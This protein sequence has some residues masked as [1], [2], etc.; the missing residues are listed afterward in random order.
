MQSVE[1]DIASMLRAQA[2]ITRATQAVDAAFITLPTDWVK[3]EQV[4]YACCGGTLAMADYWTGPIA[5]GP[6]C[7]CGCAWGDA[8]C[9]YRIVGDCIEFLPHPRVDIN[10]PPVALNVVYYAKPKPLKVAA[11]TNA[12][13]ERH[14]QIYL[15]GVVRY[16]AHVG[17]GRRSR[18]TDDHA[19]QR[20]RRR[21]QQ[22][23]RGCPVF[24]RT[25]ARRAA[26]VLRHERQQPAMDARLHPLG[27]RVEYV[28]GQ[29]G[30]R[31]R[32][33]IPAAARWHL[34]T[35]RC[36]TRRPDR[37]ASGH[38]L[39]QRRCAVHRLIAAMA[40]LVAWPALAQTPT[41]DAVKLR[42]SGQIGTSTSGNL[43]VGSSYPFG[44]GKSGNQRNT[45]VGVGTMPVINNA[46]INV[47]VGYNAM[48]V[49]ISSS[50]EV[51]IGMQALSR[52]VSGAFNTAVG[53]NAGLGIT[54]GNANT[55]LGH[56]AMGGDDFNPAPLTSGQSVALGAW[57]MQEA[58][59]GG[60]SACVGTNSCQS[61]TTG[62]GN[63]AVGN[64]AL[65]GGPGAAAVNT[66]NDASNNVAIGSLALRSSQVNDQTA[67]GWQ[68]LRDNTTGI[69]HVA[70]GTLNLA[71]SVN[72]IRNTAIGFEVMNA[73]NGGS[74][75]TGVG[76]EGI[77]PAGDRQRQHGCRV[78]CLPQADHR[79]VEYLPWRLRR[80]QRAGY[81]QR[82][83]PHRR[84]QQR[85]YRH[86]GGQQHAAHSRH[87]LDAGHSRHQSR[88]QQSTGCV[89]WHGSSGR[90]DRL[91]SVQCSAWHCHRLASRQRGA[92]RR[93]G[94]ACAGVRH[95]RRDSQAGGVRWHQ[96]DRRHD[97]RQ[98]RR[99]VSGC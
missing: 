69:E 95:E 35:H 18:A 90:R 55:A 74:D 3:F 86:R 83:H 23:E 36:A 98:H 28:V 73:L 39:E 77:R 26:G 43:A 53:S 82:Q 51:A 33:A 22:M 61:I 54:T 44:D 10:H 58:T 50:Q 68:A 21:R 79:S 48:N 6:A 72:D 88:V 91:R 29:K 94:K 85:G 9:A 57:S 34:Q 71:K 30:R 75:N 97:H 47:A 87:Q 14:Y 56:G 1:T 70:V 38:A 2:M 41:Y 25:A 8:V 81:G 40:M 96:H 99:R 11:D 45:A 17:H 7:T 80:P 78:H 27:R 59:T 62:N 89:P 37:L 63:V 19:V 66:G 20:G 52:D 76:A 64:Y 13:L 93:W 32:D 84:R 92:G 67:V 24:R 12:I 60:G 46:G 5:C 65:A 31:R 16:G 49:A 42:P 15:F 4:S